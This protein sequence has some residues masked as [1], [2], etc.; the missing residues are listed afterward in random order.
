MTQ[1]TVS[2]KLDC[3]G[4]K[5]KVSVTVPANVCRLKHEVINL[6][7]ARAINF[8]DRELRVEIKEQ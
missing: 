4:Y 8:L 6:I 7:V 1:V 3:M 2:E 5:G